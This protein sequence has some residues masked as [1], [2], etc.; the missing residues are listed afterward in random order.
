[1]GVDDNSRVDPCPMGVKN[2]YVILD[3]ELYQTYYPQ[4]NA[5]WC[6]KLGKGAEATAYK[7]KSGNTNVYFTR[8][9]YIYRYVVQDT[10]EETAL[11]SRHRVAGITKVME[12]TDDKAIILQNGEYKFVTLSELEWEMF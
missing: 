6:I 4:Y 12:T 9:N 3:E 7:Q 11:V 5:T 10:D 1:I 8:C 2:G